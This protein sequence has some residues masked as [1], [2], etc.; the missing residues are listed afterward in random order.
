MHL[1]FEARKLLVDSY[2]ALRRGDTTLG[3]RVAYRMTVRQLEA[4]IRLV[5][6]SEIDLSEIQEANHDDG[7]GG[8]DALVMR[9]R[10][11]EEAVMRDGTGRVDKMSLIRKE[12]YL[13]V[14]D[15]DNYVVE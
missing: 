1:N 12:G 10:Q 9:L 11:H 5:D 14:V 6:S 13:I 7:D 8:N 15:Y 2:V 3:S 4:L